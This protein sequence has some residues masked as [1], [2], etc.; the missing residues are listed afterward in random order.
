[1]LSPISVHMLGERF[2]SEAA[3][4][5]QNG[6]A[7]HSTTGLAIN[8]STQPNAAPSQRWNGSPTSSPID[9]TSSGTL[10]AALTTS[11]RVKSLSSG[12]GP[13]SAAGTTGSSAMPQIGQ[14]PG[15]SRTI[16]GCIGQVYLVPAAGVPS[17]LWGEGGRAAA[18]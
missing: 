1:M 11:R 7:A 9:S 6:Q 17:P 18:G 10:S 14:S 16:C 4:R 8:S 3:N 15:A 12:F 5:R 2:R 13:G